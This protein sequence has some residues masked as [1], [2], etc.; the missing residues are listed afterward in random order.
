MKIRT[1]FAPSPTGYMH[2]GNLR[3]CLYGYLFAKQN[4]GEFI[5][6]IEDTDQER[7]VEGAIDI[8]YRTLDIAGIK[9]DEGPKN[10]GN[11]GP[12]V[13]SER[14]AIYKEYAE[15]LIELG[16]AY[17]CFCTKD[18]L[19][20][21]KDDKGIRRYN[22]KCM[23]LSK[24]EIEEKLKNNTPYVIRQNIPLEGV[25]SYHD[26]VFGDISVPNI[27]MED[28]ILL[29]SDGMPTYNFANV[30]DDHL[31]GIT[32][33]MR[34]MEY[35]SSTPKYNLIYDAFGWKRPEY[36]HLP[37]IMKDEKRK[38]S[39]RHGDANFEDFY[40]KG[41][42]PEAIVNYIALLGWHPN[43]NQEKMTMQEMIDM[44]SVSGI[45]RSGAIFDEMK[46]AWLNSEYIKS[47]PLDEFIKLSKP[48]YNLSQASKYYE[49]E[50]VAEILK[51]RIDKFAQIPEKIDFICDF[52]EY[53]YHWFENKKNKVSLEMAQ[54]ILEELTPR[55]ENLK[56]YTQ[57][58]MKAEI[59]KLCE[60]K[61]Y[62]NGQ[63][64]LTMRLA[65]T[66]YQ[67]TAGGATEVAEIVGKEETIRRMKFSLELLK[68]RNEE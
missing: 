54:T 4:N 32:H 58:N 57:E 50:K 27:D 39:K 38:L 8:I 45:S 25:S 68:N 63:V 10:P 14:K 60:E 67:S 6:R 7:Y 61:S 36:I 23:H 52:K 35:L 48:Y 46:M 65:V 51:T 29:K 13:Q 53:D 47:M 43:S 26:M 34:G 18:E 56:E 62:K 59:A 30:I 17:R 66:G 16:G 37:P 31:M 42:L 11:C 22:K 41:Y 2:I 1:R 24:E 40:Q 19:E 3:T 20:E 21:M 5:L 44:F 28:N 49:Y 9:F 15:K 12:Y 64:F 55:I 33:V